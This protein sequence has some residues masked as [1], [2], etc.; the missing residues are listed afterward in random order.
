MK[1]LLIISL[2]KKGAAPLDTLGISDALE[3]RGVKHTLLVS[4]GNEL[5]SRFASSDTR[6]V[7]AVPTFASNRKSFFLATFSV[8]PL[9]LLREISRSAPDAI[10]STHFHPWLFFVKLYAKARN[11]SW[12]YSIHESPFWNKEGRG[13]LE[14]SLEIGFLR[15]AAGI[16][17][18]SDFIARNLKE[19][20]P[21]KRIVTLPIGPHGLQPD[22]TSEQPSLPAKK[23][24]RIVCIGRIES[25]K[26]IGMLIESYSLLHKKALAPF[27]LVIA[28]AGTLGMPL[29]ENDGLILVNR[30]L[31]MEEIASLY[32]SAD[33]V[34]IPYSNA[35]QSGSP[36]WAMNYGVPV[37]TTD[38]GGLPE[39]VID[40]K[41]GLVVKAGDASAFADALRRLIENVALRESMG[42]AAHKLG[43]TERSWEK[44]AEL[45]EESLRLRS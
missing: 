40:G 16:F 4:D 7:I 42:A 25:H 29:P 10:V 28:G 6:T 32:A 8:R 20:L 24:L 36:A 22:K 31:T 11:V 3:S 23:N 2:Q 21:K 38:A 9:R 33:I 26:G 15:S 27:E 35:S 34:A 12:W 37:V 45:V 14:H 39:Q 19:H 17:C 18:Y 1:K 13:S 44:A 43:K 5:L 41:T 30:W